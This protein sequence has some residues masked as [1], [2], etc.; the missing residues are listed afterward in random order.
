MRI[1]GGSIGGRV[2][3]PP[4]SAKLRP[5]TDRARE[6]LMNM[7]DSRIEL[8]GLVAADFFSGTGAI[9][10]ELCS[11]GA[12]SV[13][14][15]EKQAKLARYQEGL[16]EET[17]LPLHILHADALPFLVADYEGEACELVFA[18]PPYELPQM[19]ALPDLLLAWKGTAPE[20][21]VVVEHRKTMSF[22][23]HPH[24]T[25]QRAYGEAVFSFFLK[26]D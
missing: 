19:N 7:L 26:R 21:L 25:E 16:A 4:K 8:D 17:N 10:L 6:G 5:T 3:P 13:L 22:E 12:K 15:V 2:F 20:A 1:I 24:F 9:G 11:R 18:D 14:S 23:K